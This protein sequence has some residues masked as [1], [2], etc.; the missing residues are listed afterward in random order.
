MMP[1]DPPRVLVCSS[2]GLKGGAWRL[3]VDTI[4]D[5]LL[6]RYGDDLVL[7]H[8]GAPG[9][10]T[11]V[12]DWCDDHGLDEQHHRRHPVDWR[13]AKQELGKQW[14]R[15]GNDR[16]S[17]MR[18]T[19]NPRLIVGLHP[20]FHYTSGGTSDML[21]KGVLTGV[22]SWLITTPDADRGEWV[23]LRKYPQERIDIA[24]GSLAAAGWEPARTGPAPLADA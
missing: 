11:F 10:D 17:H 5:R 14:R 24:W 8:G 6:A 16:N 22:P 9:G 2:R 7:I 3:T 13:R 12:A 4:C 1:L 18:V 21:L 23:Q 19:E 15:A 20:W